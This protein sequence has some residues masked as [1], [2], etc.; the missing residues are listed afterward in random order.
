MTLTP[1]DDV[2]DV[3]ADVA[4]CFILCKQANH[5]EENISG[6]LGYSFFTVFRCSRI[7]LFI[8]MSTVSLENWLKC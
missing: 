5:I 1:F 8:E 4:V 7:E 6:T 3:I 2:V